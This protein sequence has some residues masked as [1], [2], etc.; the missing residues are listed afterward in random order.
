MAIRFADLLREAQERLRLDDAD[1]LIHFY[2]E[3]TDA[4]DRGELAQEAPPEPMW[5]NDFLRIVDAELLDD[6]RENYRVS[7]WHIVQDS[8]LTEFLA[9]WEAVREQGR[10]DLQT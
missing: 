6:E 8:D 3:V 4:I 5:M 9:D 10:K 2:D 1:T 7:N